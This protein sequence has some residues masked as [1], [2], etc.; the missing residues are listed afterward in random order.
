MIDYK[1]KIIYSDNTDFSDVS[2]SQDNSTNIGLPLVRTKNNFLHIAGATM[3]LGSQFSYSNP[4]IKLNNEG[5]NIENVI[6]DYKKN[7]ELPSTYYITE[8]NSILKNN[9]TKKGIIKEILSFKSLTNNWDGYGS[10]PLEVEASSNALYII[11]EL[12]DNTIASLSEIFPNPNGTVSLTWE[13]INDEILSLEIGNNTM[14]YFSSLLNKETLYFNNV[15]IN[16]R[17]IKEIVALVNR[18]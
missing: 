14:S 16:E 18:L 5:Y 8:I 6:A 2:N 13:N 12:D 7:I 4:V 15:K 11:N 17:N 1:E 10:I 9:Y 3:L